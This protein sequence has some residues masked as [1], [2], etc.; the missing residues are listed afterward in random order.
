MAYDNQDVKA[1]GWDDVI[2]KDDEFILLPEGE[3]EFTV[4]EVERSRYDGGEKLP[5]CNMAVVSCLIQTPQGDTTIKNR[6]FLTTATEGIISSFF[7]AVGLKK[8]GQPL[9]MEWTKVTGLRGRC[10]V[11]QRT[12]NGNTYN[13]I[14]RFLQPAEGGTSSATPSAPAAPAWG[15]GR[16]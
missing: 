4:T 11:S 9:R 5:P 7:A 1:L 15:A 6:L 3:Y 12:Y 8:K 13:E 2:T 14:K 16:Y 10:K